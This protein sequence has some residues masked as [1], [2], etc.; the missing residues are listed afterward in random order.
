MR[1]LRFIVKGQ[2]IERDSENDIVYDTDYNEAVAIVSFLT[3]VHGSNY[4]VT[5][6][7][8]SVLKQID[9]GVWKGSRFK[10]QRILTFAEWVLLCKKLGMEIYIDRKATYTRE[11]ISELV[12]TV[13]NY[14][15]LDKASWIN[16]GVDAAKIIREHDPNARI[17]V[18]SNPTESNIVTWKELNESGRGVFFDGNAA[19]LT[20]E[21][22]KI[23]S[24]AGYE[25][26]CYYVDFD[27]ND[28]SVVFNKINTLVEWGVRGITTDKYRVDEA[29]DY[30][31]AK[32]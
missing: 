19:T 27:S 10:G 16:V 23:G 22:V 4:S 13:R 20:K 18:L 24:D 15:M 29:F 6:L 30:L 12:N 3:R 8:Y 2:T 28:K 17:G 31:L 26:E 11:G 9:F 1:T 7:P 32:F 21:A 25:V 5:D 14:G